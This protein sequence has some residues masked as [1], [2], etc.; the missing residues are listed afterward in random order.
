M[1][2]HKNLIEHACHWERTT[3]DRLFVTQPMGGG[4]AN[5]RTFTWR[6]FMDE[7]RRMASYLVGLQLPERSQI[8]ICSKNCVYWV[9]A[10]LATWMAGHV[11]VPIYPTLTPDTVRYI[12]EHSESKLLFVGKLDPI[13]DEMKRGVPEHLP[14]VA[15]PLAPPNDHLQWDRIV[16]EHEPLREL[17]DRAP[18]ELATI[19]YT[20]GSTGRP[21]GVMSAFGPMLAATIGIVR[22]IGSTSDD[23]YLSYL[24][25][26]HAMER[27]LAECVAFYSGGQ[28]F[29]A[30]ALDT[31]LHDL[32]RARPTLFM[33]VP[34]L[35]SR[36]QLGVFE[37]LPPERLTRLLAI[38]LLSRIVKRKILRQLGLD[39]VRFAGSGSAPIP[40]ELIVWYRHLGLELL[41]GYGMT[42]NF[43]YSHVTRPGRVRP[44]F[45]GEPYADVRCRIADD[46]EVQVKSPGTMLGY[47]KLPEETR[48][49]FTEDG[50]LKTGDIGEI[51]AEGRLRITGRI[52]E[53][54]KTS[55]GKFISPAPIE[56]LLLN[57]PRIELCCVAGAG[58]PQPYAMVQLSED[59]RR[60]A[61]GGGREALGREL[62]AHLATVNESLLTFEK[63]QFVSVVDDVWLPEN[64]FLTPTMK[65][66]RTRIEEA[67]RPYAE[68]W[69][70]G[71]QPV[72]WQGGE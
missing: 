21:K 63:L 64:G 45:V 29:F 41:E 51:D 47:F 53:I 33:S 4:D 69:Y 58:F 48:E 39:R 17:R 37:K 60:M 55:K 31:F 40:A 20:S 24:P 8:A 15:F 27:W 16:A 67:Y 36:F 57:H 72:I 68:A 52:K 10:D 7:A 19:I 34:R 30:E 65:I 59:G 54:F 42:E 22:V 49:S 38:P 1:A 66:R 50:Y 70:G 23:R 11:S 44:G 25:I 18:Q 13:W 43:S 71:Q 35:W 5:V 9:M 32:R 12:L 26:A 2:E 56:N 14:R 61:A 6:Q 46:G 62:A 28:L 3:P